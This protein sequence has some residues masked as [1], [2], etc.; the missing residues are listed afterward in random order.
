MNIHITEW[1]DKKKTVIFCLHGL[2]GSGLSFI[3]VADQLK[4]EYRIDLD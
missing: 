2:G 1:G 4:D 3:E